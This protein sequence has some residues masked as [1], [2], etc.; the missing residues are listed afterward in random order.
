V[1]ALEVAL[2]GGYPGGLTALRVRRPPLRQKQPFIDQRGLGP[3]AQRGKDPAIPA[4]MHRR[5]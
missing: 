2:L 5:Q 4:L 3:T 1:L